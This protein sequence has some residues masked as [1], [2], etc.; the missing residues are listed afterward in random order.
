MEV[1]TRDK[2]FNAAL[3]I[4]FDATGRGPGL[5]QAPVV[6]LAVEY[7]QTPEG[8]RAINHVRAVFG[9]I[10]PTSPVPVNW[11]MAKAIDAL[12]RGEA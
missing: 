8:Q 4:A 10:Q 2:L 5:G 6:E 1:A 3:Q 12:E 7:F 9:A 11:S